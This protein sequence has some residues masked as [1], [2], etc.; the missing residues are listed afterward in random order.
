MIGRMASADGPGLGMTSSDASLLESTNI[1]GTAGIRQIDLVTGVTRARVLDQPGLTATGIAV[2][3]PPRTPATVWQLTQHN[4][5]AIARDPVTLATKRTIPYEGNGQGLCDDGTQLVH[6]DGTMRL[7]L[8]D[9]VTFDKTGNVEVAGGWWNT[10]HL[11]ELECVYDN[12]QRV[13]W[14]NL[15][16]TTWMLRINIDSRSVTGIADLAPAL[17][18]ATGGIDPITGI[19]AVPNVRNEFWI[20]GTGWTTPVRIR[21]ASR[22]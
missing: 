4:G 11:G 22:P 18:G 20:S 5:V 15:V 7:T 10:A 17:A 12:G 19:A 21:L 9:P 2:S 1:N 8:R 13:V 6:S 3:K 16:G 14:A